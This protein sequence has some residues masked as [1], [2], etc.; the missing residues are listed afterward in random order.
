[1][2]DQEGTVTRHLRNWNSG[3]RDA[4]D[5]LIP[6]VYEDLR[7]LAR[8]QLA[9]ERSGHTLQATALVNEAFIKFCDQHVKH[10]Q[11]RKH[12][13]AVVGLM[14]RRVLVDHARK[15]GRAKRGSGAVQMTLHEE[16]VEGQAQT[17][18]L[19]V[20]DDALN[21]LAGMD[22]RQ[23]R[24]VELRYFAGLSVEEVAH[25]LGLSERTVKREWRIAKAWLYKEM[26]SKA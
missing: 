17:V 1:M 21:R 15:Q 16:A 3:D 2:E 14:M 22:P 24:I 18:D 7:R 25:V 12:F 6:L 11:D 13:F 9:R 4:I 19:L 10:W 8:S 23:V 20:L 5:A 26:T